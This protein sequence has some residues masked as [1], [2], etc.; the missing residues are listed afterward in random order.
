LGDVGC[1]IVIRSTKIKVTVQIKKIPARAGTNYLLTEITRY[2]VSDSKNINL[3]DSEAFSTFFS[4]LAQVKMQP[5]FA[6]LLIT[7]KLK[8]K[9]VATRAKQYSNFG[10]INSI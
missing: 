2:F 9:M 3:D 10:F 8:S 5:V 1:F 7:V 4:I 6:C